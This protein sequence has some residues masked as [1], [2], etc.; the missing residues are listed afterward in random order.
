MDL[1]ASALRIEIPIDRR[2][3]ALEDYTQIIQEQ[4]LMR[5]TQIDT[6][7]DPLLKKAQMQRKNKGFAG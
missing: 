7:E 1:L 5:E 3:Q 4:K 2:Q 6:Q